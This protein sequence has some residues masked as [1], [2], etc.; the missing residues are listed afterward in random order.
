[1]VSGGLRTGECGKI[2]HQ[3]VGN[4]PAFA[5]TAAQRIENSL[6]HVIPDGAAPIRN[7]AELKKIPG[8]PLRGAPE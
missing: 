1:M 3:S 8:S 2:S 5:A 6:H 4:A 7:L